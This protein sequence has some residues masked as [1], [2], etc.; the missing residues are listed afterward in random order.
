VLASPA[1]KGLDTMMTQERIALGK[2]WEHLNSAQLIFDDLYPRPGST[3]EAPAKD[4][5]STAAQMRKILDS[6]VG[7]AAALIKQSVGG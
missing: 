3:P 1:K 4:D 6:A 7:G 5:Y 2:L